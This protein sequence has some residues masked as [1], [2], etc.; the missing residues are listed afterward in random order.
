MKL[1]QFLRGAVCF[2]SASLGLGAKKVK[3]FT[4][5]VISRDIF[6]FLKKVIFRFST[7]FITFCLDIVMF[8]HTNSLKL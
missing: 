8:G 2:P 1:H 5:R 4:S 7:A 3:L 6:L